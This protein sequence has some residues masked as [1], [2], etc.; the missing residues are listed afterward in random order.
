MRKK[1]TLFVVSRVDSKGAKE[2]NSD[3]SLPELISEYLVAKFG[4]SRFLSK[5]I[6]GEPPILSDF[7]ENTVFCVIPAI[8]SRTP[9]FFANGYGAVSG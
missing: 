3:R 9:K 2:C 8:T 1:E 5:V 4:F 6:G 7:E